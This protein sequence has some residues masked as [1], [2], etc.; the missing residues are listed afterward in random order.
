MFAIILPGIALPIYGI[1][2]YYLRQA[3]KKGII[4]REKKSW[5]ITPK[6]IWWGI[7]EFDRESSTTILP[8]SGLALI[9]H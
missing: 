2:A 8:L 4:V 6:T 9:N 3:E 5:N 1:L 7:L